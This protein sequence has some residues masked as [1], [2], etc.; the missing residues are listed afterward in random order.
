MNCRK[1][2]SFSVW[3]RDQSGSVAIMTALLMI[4]LLSAIGLA[5][6][7][8]RAAS[9]RVEMQNALDIAVL[10]GARAMATDPIA[11]AQS[12]FRANQDMR[13][14]GSPT[15]TF[16]ISSNRIDGLLSVKIETR[17]MNVLGIKAVDM[18]VTASAGAKAGPDVCILVLDPSA[19]QALLVNGGANVSAPRCQIDVK[20]TANNAA[21]FNAGTTIAAANTCIQS[22]S[23]LDNGGSH[24]N[25]KTGCDTASDPFA[26]KLPAP[27]SASCSASSL[28]IN[29]GSVTLSPGVYCGGIN[30]NNAPNVTLLPGL[31]VIRS[32]DWNV[33]GGSWTGDGVTFYF[34][35]SSRIQ[36]NSAV[37]AT[38]TA[39]TSGTYKDIVLFEAVGLAKSPFVFNDSRNFDL[40][41]LVYLP[42][43]NVTFNGGSQA[44]AKQ[45]T[46]VVNTLILDQTVWTIDAAAQ[47]IAGG[48]A[49]G[50]SYL[51]K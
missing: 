46:L 35:D 22:T 19:S 14:T 30:F 48:G 39:P 29:G 50:I 23:I 7:Y 11:V 33:N 16:A 42:S 3:R 25:L 10:A 18:S 31:Y 20:S 26:G 28:N 17:F 21:V 24:P 27:S 15:P 49:S 6:D 2:R 34:A 9:T 13:E 41:G 40:R 4:V 43:R 12:S 36:F 51:L 45:M 1:A 44:R 47:S 8:G 37:A 32:G 5:I 38:V